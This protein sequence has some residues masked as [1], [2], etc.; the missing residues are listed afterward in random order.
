MAGDRLVA[1]MTRR[2]V[3]VLLDQM[4]GTPVAA[5]T[6]LAILRTLLEFGVPRGFCDINPAA[7]VR[8][9]KVEDR[10]HS[11]WPE[12]GYTY[13]IQY[14]PVLLQR[15]AFLG[16]ASG[17]RISDLIRMRPVDL[18][19][20]GIHV[21]IGKLRDRPHFVPLTAAQMA[22]IRSW[23]VRDL[24]FLLSG[25]GRRRSADAANRV[26]N[27]WRASVAAAPIRDLKLTIHGL[28]AT[29]IADLRSAGTEDGA[30]ADE[31]GMSVKMVSRYL[32]F[33]DKAASARASRDRRERKKAE[34]ENSG[35]V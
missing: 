20:D 15:M 16:R 22:E 2:D 13:V 34:F 30:I 17:Q 21:R 23:G 7:G 8:K 25:D 18:V 24:E 28:R 9:L 26:W 29:K 27:R 6:M 1:A 33:A 12:R 10:G 19:D 31:L 32:R 5:N 14:A 4:S 3:Y 11:P 35:G